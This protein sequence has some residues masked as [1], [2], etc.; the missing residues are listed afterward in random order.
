MDRHDT[1]VAISATYDL[2]R[3]R[4][5]HHQP[6]AA[7]DRTRARK[8]ATSRVG[9]R[10]ARLRQAEP[11]NGRMID[12]LNPAGAQDVLRQFRFLPF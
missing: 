12:C 7:A 8:L 10:E 4:E 6:D 9:K 5:R 3:I 11:P 1:L 2:L